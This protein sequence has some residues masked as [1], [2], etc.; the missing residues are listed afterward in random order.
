MAQERRPAAP[1]MSIRQRVVACVALFAL[2]AM[3]ACESWI[4]KPSLYGTV[5]AQVQRRDST[6]IPGAR[7]QLYTGQRP[8]GYAVTDNNGVF[9]F[10]DVPDG[11][12]GVRVV[13]PTGYFSINEIIGGPD[14]SVVRDGLELAPGENKYVRFRLLK[15]GLGKVSAYV[16][17]ADRKAMPGIR[18]VLYSSKGSVEEGVTNQ[19][20]LFQF[21]AVPLGNYG[22]F[23]LRPAAYVDSAENPLP[24]RDGFVVDE[25]STGTATFQFARCVGT[26]DVRVRDNTGAPVPGTLLTF[27]GAFGVQDSVL[28][29]QAE[30]HVSDL[31][32]GQY[33]VRIR[34]PVGWTAN[35]GRGTTFQDN[36][37]IHR[38]TAANVTLNV[39]RI[40]RGTVRVR[41]VDDLGAPVE[42]VRT[43]LYTGQGL[44]RDVVTG[45]DGSVSMAD[46]LINAEYGVRVVPRAGYSAPDV[47]G[48][49][50]NDGIK[51]IDGE[52]R[53][54]V[55]RFKRD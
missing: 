12:Y 14:S 10:V 8:I 2:V 5:T 42:N 39:T 7:V 43:V 46:L 47:S 9:T 3:G 27:Y 22:V 38:G 16:E 15:S 51:L 29:A 48:S 30:R 31:A 32:C 20:G 36:I 24:S 52:V 55:F 34:P 6:V 33:G 11:V 40:G 53:E 21:A 45:P 44:V 54:F 37:S 19:S 25:G 41:V 17:D 4:T 35:E 50:F 28:G 1:R 18:V 13:P 49:T 26:L 23:A